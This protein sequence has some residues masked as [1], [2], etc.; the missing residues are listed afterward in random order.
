MRGQLVA[1]ADTVAIGVHGKRVIAAV[2]VATQ[3]EDGCCRRTIHGGL[4]DEE[5]RGVD[6]AVVAH[7]ELAGEDKRPCT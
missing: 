1:I 2:T 5:V 6:V 4:Y 3:L 7:G